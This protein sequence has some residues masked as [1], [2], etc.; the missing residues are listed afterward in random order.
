MKIPAEIRNMI[1]EL[2]IEQ[3]LGTHLLIFA[4]VFGLFICLDFHLDFANRSSPFSN[5]CG[6]VKVVIRLIGFYCI[7]LLTYHFIVEVQFVDYEV[8]HNRITHRGAYIPV[9]VN[10]KLNILYP[11]ASCTKEQLNFLTNNMRQA[12][13]IELLILQFTTS[14]LNE[15]GH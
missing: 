4:L 3:R 12:A 10:F 6:Q 15:L 5:F 11:R 9:Y 7:G 2:T 14:I 13:A 1:W 8:L